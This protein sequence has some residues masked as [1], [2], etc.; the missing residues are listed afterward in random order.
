MKCSHPECTGNHSGN[1]RIREMCPAAQEK[2][3]ASW[4][5]YD[6]HL[7]EKQTAAHVARFGSASSDTVV[8]PDA[9]LDLRYMKR[10]EYKYMWELQKRIADADERMDA[11]LEC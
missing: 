6:Y 7:W 3:R 9:A 4:L 11:L 8:N 1:W 5:A 10:C 2:R